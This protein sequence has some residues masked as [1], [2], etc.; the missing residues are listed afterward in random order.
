MQENWTGVKRRMG[1]NRRCWGMERDW[2]QQEL[3][4][5][6]GEKQAVEED[7][8]DEMVGDGGQGGEGIMMKKRYEE[9]MRDHRIS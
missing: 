5:N 4:E 1:K 9:I 6:E 7:K 3:E 2:G 8:R